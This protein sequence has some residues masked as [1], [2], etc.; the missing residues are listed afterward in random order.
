MTALIIVATICLVVG[1]FNLINARAGAKA[2]R[3]RNRG[4][5]VAEIEEWDRWSRILLAEYNELTGLELSYP[6][7]KFTSGRFDRA[8]YNAFSE[9]YTL[10][11]AN[12]WK[13][14]TALETLRIR[15]KLPSDDEIYSLQEWMYKKKIINRPTLYTSLAYL[16]QQCVYRAVHKRDYK[17]GGKDWE[18]EEAAKQKWEEIQS[19]HAWMKNDPTDR[20]IN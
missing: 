15:H 14:E 19:K 12:P 2:Y 20:W 17:Y 9:P 18:G 5:R 16:I 3:A 6:E 4:S 1:T 11:N 13:D 8:Y 10:T 7:I